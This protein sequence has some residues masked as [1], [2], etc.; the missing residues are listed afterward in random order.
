VSAARTVIWASVL[1]ESEAQVEVVV[2][3]IMAIGGT[4]QGIILP[5]DYW[6]GGD[7]LFPF[8]T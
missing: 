6:D 2:P 3:P 5:K 4:G 7:D 8:R 1:L